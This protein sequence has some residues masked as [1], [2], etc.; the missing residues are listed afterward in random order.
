VIS[1]IAINAAKAEHLNTV[2]FVGHLVDLP[3]ICYEL[4]I[5][6]GFYH[7][8]FIIPPNPGLGTAYGALLEAEN[9]P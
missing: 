3:S 9:M 4:K 8:R 7:S 5:V 2:I 6:E 1:V